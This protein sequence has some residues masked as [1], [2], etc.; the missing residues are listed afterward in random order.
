MFSFSTLISVSG[1]FGLFSGKD[2]EEAQEHFEKAR[3]LFEQKKYDEAIVEYKAAITDNPR[4]DNAYVECADAYLLMKDLENAGLCLRSAIKINPKNAKAHNNLGCCYHELGYDEQAEIEF[5]K[6]A[7]LN[8]IYLP[9]VGSTKSNR[10]TKIVKNSS[11]DKTRN[12]DYFDN[13]GVEL[14]KQK[15]YQEAI[16]LHKKALELGTSYPQITYNNLGRGYY[17]NG[18][19][20]EAIYCFDKALEIEPN[21]ALAIKNRELAMSKI[22][23]NESE[24]GLGNKRIRW[25]ME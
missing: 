18:E 25:S 17:N 23:D 5:E 20:E 7:E 19:Y 24:T 13:Q 12:G 9:N 4:F 22:Y 2:N 14:Q 11:E 10:P 21:Y 1:I 16:I 3:I 8:P 6:A 15:Q